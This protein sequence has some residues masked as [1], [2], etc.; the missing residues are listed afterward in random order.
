MSII[1]VFIPDDILIAQKN[2][3]EMII[4]VLI[5]FLSCKMNNENNKRKL[6][7]MSM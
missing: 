6:I 1:N 3:K 7:R 2:K 5:V 4:T